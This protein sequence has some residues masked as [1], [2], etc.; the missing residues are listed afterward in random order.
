M[1]ASKYKGSLFVPGEKITPTMHLEILGQTRV[2]PETHVETVPS[3]AEED[4][5]ELQAWL[6]HI[7]NQCSHIT[8][9]VP[10]IPVRYR[11][12]LIRKQ[13]QED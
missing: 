5:E 11:E 6:N 4:E 12:L 2:A 7:D 3:L 10:K 1:H 9:P 13:T 8:A